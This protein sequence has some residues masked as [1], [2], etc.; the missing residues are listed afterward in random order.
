LPSAADC[1]IW[2]WYFDC[3][4]HLLNFDAPSREAHRQRLQVFGRSPGLI[5]KQAV[6]ILPELDLFARPSRG[7]GRVKRLAVDRQAD[8]D[9]PRLP[10]I[11]RHHLLES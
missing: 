9:Q 2:L 4:E 1:I 6:V 11:M 7:F 8:L 5:V 10:T 3:S